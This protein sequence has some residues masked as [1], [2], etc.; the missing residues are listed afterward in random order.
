MAAM[1]RKSKTEI[2]YPTGDGKPLAETGFHVEVILYLYQALKDRY[3]GVSDVLVS[4]NNFFYYEEGNPKA[5]VSPDVYVV[6][7]VP[8]KPLR[9]YY[10]L[11]KEGKVPSLVVEVTSSSTRRQD[12]K[13][14]ELYARL[15]VPEYFMFDPEGDYLKPPLQGFR[16]LKGEYLSI[17]P[18]ADGSVTSRTTGLVFRPEGDWVRLVDAATGEPLPTTDEWREKADQE[19]EARRKAEARAREFEEEIARLR[20]QSGS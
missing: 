20:R 16:L 1:S 18:A 12:V 5:V 19:A 13:K 10:L 2:E 11:W 4:A 15:G 6:K 17:P 14:K 3:A 8:S 9:D 7:G